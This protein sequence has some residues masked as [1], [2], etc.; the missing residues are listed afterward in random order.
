M[1]NG[2][3]MSGENIDTN[4]LEDTNSITVFGSDIQRDIAQLSGRLLSSTEQIGNDN[5]SDKLSITINSL[6]RSND[7]A[8]NKKNKKFLFF[9][10]HNV[11]EEEKENEIVIKDVEQVEKALDEHRIN[12]LMESTLYEQLYNM[13]Q[14]FIVRLDE[15]INVA[16]NKKD[17]L[18]NKSKSTSGE[19]AK[20]IDNLCIQLEHRIE[21][22]NVSKMLSEQQLVQIRVLLETTNSMARG[23]QSTLYNVIPL[24]K[25]NVTNGFNMKSE[26]VSDEDIIYERKKTNKMLIESLGEIAH[27]HEESVIKKKTA[28]KVFANKGGT[29]E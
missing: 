8:D 7:N 13:N 24:W 21:D 14:Q 2:E 4:F 16:R 27:I 9:K 11:Y 5:I 28:E 25:N 20:H 26:N 17:E 1:L 6:I 29:N 18:V 10:L 15:C 19:K 3:K 12:L 22:L 23:I